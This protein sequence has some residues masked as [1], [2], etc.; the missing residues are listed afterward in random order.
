MLAFL[1]EFENHP[2]FYNR[3]KTKV[4]LQN[5]DVI[6]CWVYFLPNYPDNYLELPYFDNYDSYGEHKLP[7]VTRYQRDPDDKLWFPNW[8]NFS[9]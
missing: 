8:G 4:K 7:Y 3:L 5:E 9:S 6:D 2:D 1:D